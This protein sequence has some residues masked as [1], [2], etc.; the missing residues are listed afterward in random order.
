LPWT[1]MRPRNRMLPLFG[2]DEPIPMSLL[3]P[4]Q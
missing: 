3:L 1:G 2:C 4:E